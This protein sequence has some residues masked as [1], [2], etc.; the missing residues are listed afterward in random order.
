MTTAIIAMLLM[1]VSGCS[2]AVMAGKMFMGDPKTPSVFRQRTGIDLIEEDV[3]SLIVCTTP[4]F[5]KAENSALDRDVIEG[6]YRHFRR[7]DIACINPNEVDSWLG[8]IG[9]VWDDPSE[10]AQEFD[11]K[12]LIHFD[13]DS[14]SYRESNSP[15]FFRGNCHGEVRVYEA[16]GKGDT[17]QAYLIFQHEFKSSYPNH[18]PISSD[19]MS[20]RTFAEQYNR[21]VAEELARLFYD[22]P[23]A[24]QM[25]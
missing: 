24:D 1:T 18:Y 7:Q 2:L 8:R 19:N 15:N 21:R 16:R 13:I 17:R 22:A 12:Y 9:G 3:T 23:A 20:E 14:V 11:A 10:I 6:V 5:V 4:A 25:F